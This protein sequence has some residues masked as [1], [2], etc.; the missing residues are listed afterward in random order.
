[1][2]EQKKE[3]SSRIISGLIPSSASLEKVRNKKS[4]RVV[5]I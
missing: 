3:K 4:N 2:M 1:M 5:I